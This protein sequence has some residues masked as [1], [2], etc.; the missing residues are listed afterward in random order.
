VSAEGSPLHVLL[1]DDHPLLRDGLRAAL[2]HQFADLRIEEAGAAAEAL[3]IIAVGPP[4][5]AL[6]D[7][8]LPGTNGLDLAR[9]I[10][11]VDPKIKVLMV[12][13]DL[14]PWTVNEALQAGASGFVAKTNSGAT[15]PEALRVVLSGGIFLCPDA[16]AALQR[17]EQ[18]GVAGSELPGPAILSTR[19]REVL[20]YLAHGENTKNTAA[21]LQISPKTV[22]THRQHI[23]RKLG[24][25]NVAALAR[26]AIRH[27]LTRP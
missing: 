22:E 11:A 13:A 9:Q 21:L 2:Q 25:N 8:N 23:L 19:E 5:L 17:S 14:D 20:R 24:T 6:L 16:Q 4:H 26:Y 18:H 12:A 27:G 1:V 10:R 3:A 15:L 7:V